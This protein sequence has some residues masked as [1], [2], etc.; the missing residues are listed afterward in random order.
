MQMMGASSNQGGACLRAVVLFLHE[1]GV[2]AACKLPMLAWIRD[3]KSPA[4]L[5]HVDLKIRRHE[6]VLLLHER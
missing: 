2:R 3:V 6:T 1:N 5:R 4:S